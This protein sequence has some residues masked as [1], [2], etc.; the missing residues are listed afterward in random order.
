MPIAS[1]RLILL[2]HGQSQWNKENRFTGWVDVPLSVEGEQEARRAAQLI[3]EAG[4]SPRAAFTSYLK[5]AIK[6]LWIALEELDLMYIP[7]G[8][9]WRLNEKHYGNITGLNKAETADRFGEEQVK[10]WRRAYDVAPP[11]VPTDS[12]YHPACDPKYAHVPAPLLP[13]TESLKDTIH[14]LLPYWQHEMAPRIQDAPGDY[15]VVA[16]GNSLRGLVKHLLGWDEAR[17]LEFNLPTAI[18]YVLE[19]TEDLKV[20]YESFLISQE[21]LEKKMAE[22]AAQ[23]KR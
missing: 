18:P 14:R 4:L 9:S 8:C 12:P 15:L 2:R 21:E 7:V 6:T 20:V 23:A 13:A 3:R 22:V 5:R 1:R 10:L 19:L 16:H 11:P 17:V